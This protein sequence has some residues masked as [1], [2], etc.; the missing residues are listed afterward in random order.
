MCHWC[1]SFEETC[2]SNTNLTHVKECWPPCLEVMNHWRLG[3]SFSSPG[4]KGFLHFSSDHFP[5]CPRHITNKFNS[6]SFQ[7]C[8]RFS[9]GMRGGGIINFWPPRSLYGSCRTC[10]SL[11]VVLQGID[12][13]F[14][15]SQLS[16]LGAVHG[17]LICQTSLPSNIPSER[18]FLTQ[19]RMLRYKGLYS[20]PLQ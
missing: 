4:W 1:L 6:R 9:N 12:S 10:F 5:V 2:Q 17:K 15:T 14:S 19:A 8:V 20:W 16:Q 7:A 13:L 11:W 3:N 18:T